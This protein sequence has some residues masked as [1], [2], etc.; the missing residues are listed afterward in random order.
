MAEVHHYERVTKRMKTWLAVYGANAC[1]MT[2]ACL[3]SK[4]SSSTISNW[5]RGS[6]DFAALRKEI[7]ES[8]IDLA[9]SKLMEMI[10]KGDNLGAIC[11]FLKCKGKHRGYVEKAEHTM[12][13]SGTLL[14]EID[15]RIL[16]KED[17]IGGEKPTDS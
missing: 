13:H 17:K 12:D 3:A 6:K 15:K 5:T 4:V 14:L 16:T 11:F 8:M 2:A 10:K 7:E 1:N 9:E